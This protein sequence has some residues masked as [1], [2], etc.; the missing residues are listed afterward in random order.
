[1]AKEDV[2]LKK[3]MSD[4]GR[5]ADLVN[6][7]IF[8]GKQIVKPE[9]LTLLNGESDLYLIDKNGRKKTIMRYRDVIMKADFGMY[10]AVIAEE[11][12]MK[13]HYAM[14]VRNMLYDALSYTEQVAQI[15]KEHV[16]KGEILTDEEFLSGIK[17][18][19]KIIPVIT[20][21]LYYGEKE[22]D[23]H[24][25]L[26]GMMG[27]NHT[28]LVQQEI[29]QVLPNYRINLVHAGNIEKLENY[30]SSLQLVFGML[31]YK[32]DKNKLREYIQ[33][34]RRELSAV[35]EETYDVIGILLHEEKR[36]EKYRKKEKVGLSMCQAIEEMIKD[37]RKEGIK[38]EQVR[39]AKELKG[40]LSDEMIAEK[41][42]LSLE[43]VRDL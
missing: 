3:Y 37:G 30:K 33:E 5:F 7:R 43:I 32:S 9:N 20:L 26:Y 10:F 21:V 31:K 25:D 40:I 42:N 14:P 38:E 11:N 35:D 22:W 27:L 24:L 18:E 23:G 28:E 34:N 12:Q 4:K 6:G 8:D 39:I 41:T 19:D 29:R 15:K 13:I 17:K 1:M 16:E 2:V 36:L